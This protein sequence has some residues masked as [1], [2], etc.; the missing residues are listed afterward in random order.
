M[1]AHPQTHV[2][3]YIH[4]HMHSHKDTCLHYTVHLN[5]TTVNKTTKQH[6]SSSPSTAGVT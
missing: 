3:T 6:A 1:N 2:R 5:T 4:T